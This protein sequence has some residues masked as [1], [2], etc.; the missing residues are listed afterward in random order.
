VIGAILAGG[1]SARFG[2]QPKG[3]SPVGGVRIIDRIAG[4]LRGVAA[5]LI[6]VSNAVESATWLPRIR[7]VSDVRPERGS[8]VGLHSALSYAGTTVM[9]VAW[10]MPFVSVDLLRL[11][12]DRGRLESFATV[13]EGSGG[14]EPFCAMYT[15]ACVPIIEAALDAGELR[16]STLLARLPSLTRVSTAELTLVGDPARLFFNVNDL[17]DLKLAEEMASS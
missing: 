8:L 5:D 1:A 10:D 17:R 11:I 13:P 15:P 4:A 2:G 16:M 12:R 6:V 7:V 3:L 14:L 9:V